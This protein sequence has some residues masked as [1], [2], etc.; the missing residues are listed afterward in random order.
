MNLQHFDG[1][2]DCSSLYIYD[3]LIV[4]YT[5]TN[6]YYDAIKLLSDNFFGQVNH[7]EIIS[8]VYQ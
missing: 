8:R 1:Q 3:I 7:V 5:F 6:K 2:F 4:N